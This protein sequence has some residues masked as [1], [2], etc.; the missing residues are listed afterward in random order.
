MNLIDLAI[1]VVLLLSV[2]FG[3]Y[4]GFIKTVSGIVAFFASWIIAFSFYP[5]LASSISHIPD[6][7]SKVKYYTTD[8]SRIGD[9]A[10]TAVNSLAD[11]TA[12]TKT[13]KKIGIP[14]PI[15]NLLK[16]NI[17]NQ[18]FEDKKIT[19][20]GQYFNET[21]T[22]FAINVLSFLIIFLVVRLLCI[23]V[24]HAI[25][26]AMKLPILSHFNGLLG[27]IFGFLSGLLLLFVIFSVLPVFF[28][29]VPSPSIEKLVDQSFLARLFY[30]ANIINGILK[31]TL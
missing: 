3:L 19:T 25:D 10:D 16:K 29:A 11:E 21:V 18:S 24:L 23:F 9:Y 7:V 13:I 26:Y 31:G 28:S 30:K 8:S 15:D 27:G 14:A 4:K 12:I 1:F 17:M 2:V 6:L 5:M 20:I 22:S